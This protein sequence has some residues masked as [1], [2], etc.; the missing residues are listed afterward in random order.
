MRLAIIGAFSVLG[1]ALGILHIIPLHLL[2]SIE[3]NIILV[4]QMGK[5][6]RSKDKQF[7]IVVIIFN[8]CG[9]TEA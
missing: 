8:T 7:S 5:L 6:Q 4:L 2:M 1:T 9:E 3:L